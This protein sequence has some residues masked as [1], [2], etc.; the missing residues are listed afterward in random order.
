MSRDKDLDKAKATEMDEVKIKESKI[1]NFTVQKKVGASKS[2]KPTEPDS[3]VPGGDIDN[4]IS[5]PRMRVLRGGGASI[6]VIEK[7]SLKQSLDVSTSQQESTKF[8]AN[9]G[10][11]KDGVNASVGFSMSKSTEVKTGVAATIDKEKVLA[12]VQAKGKDGKVPLDELSKV[13]LRQ[14]GVKPEDIENLEA[15]DAAERAQA[16]AR[17]SEQFSVA[18][19]GEKGTE[20]RGG[21][22]V[23]G[24]GRGAPSPEG[25]ASSSVGGA[26]ANEVAATGGAL[27]GGI[28]SLAG[29]SVR[30]AGA[31]AGALGRSVAALGQGLMSKRARP[32][33]VVSVLPTISEYRV[34]KVEEAA[35]NYDKAV[36]SFWKAP[37]MAV[38]RKEI[39]ERARQTGLSV[40]DAMAKMKPGGEWADLHD[41]FVKEVA[42]SPDATHSKVAMDKALSSWVRQYDHGTEE[43][44]GADVEGNPGHKKARNRIEATKDAMEAKA[45]E[46][47]VFGGESESHA[48]RLKAAV[49]A[50]MERIKEILHA[51]G[52]RFSG[53]EADHAAP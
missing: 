50:I 37:P 28:A 17:I 45:A 19:R 44:L 51:V 4:I 32:F 13:L 2:S 36:D 11:N 25:G 42:A 52:Q 40:P 8:D 9:V 22:S 46:S 39:E 20:I 30:L 43:L 53:A 21:I 10:V 15:L 35:R 38:M 26:I 27:I 3:T 23:G 29:G 24:R 34:K 47:P 5:M 6:P 41:K 12:E 48:E 7:S 1:P 14:M 18:L 49:E 31:A 33:D 16:V